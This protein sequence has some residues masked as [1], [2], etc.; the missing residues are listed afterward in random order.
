MGSPQAPSQF[1]SAG[2]SFY[3]RMMLTPSGL[4]GN[5][6]LPCSFSGSN[7]FWRVPASK[8]VTPT[9]KRRVGRARAGAQGHSPGRAHRMHLTVQQEIEASEDLP[10]LTGRRATVAIDQK[11]NR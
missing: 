5:R 11:V 9:V 4:G 6:R 7:W 2:S 3:V 10:S 1:D 8:A